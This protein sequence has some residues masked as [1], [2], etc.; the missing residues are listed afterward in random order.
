VNIPIC[1]DEEPGCPV[2]CATQLFVIL[3]ERSESKDLHLPH[4]RIQPEL[5]KL[6]ES[7]LIGKFE[8]GRPMQRDCRAAL[9]ASCQPTNIKKNNKR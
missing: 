2:L 3:S 7:G 1:R 9:D 5:P 6:P 8:V 4:S